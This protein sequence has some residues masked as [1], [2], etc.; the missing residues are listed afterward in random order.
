MAAQQEFWARI[1]DSLFVK[2][3]G[4]F[5]VVQ[6]LPDK[7]DLTVCLNRTF[8]GEA[9]TSS[10]IQAKGWVGRGIKLEVHPNPV[11][12]ADLG[13]TSQ[14]QWAFLQFMFSFFLF[15]GIYLSLLD[16]GWGAPE[17]WH[18]TFI[19]QFIEVTQA[20]T[21]YSAMLILAEENRLPQDEYGLEP[22]I[23]DEIRKIVTVLT[24]KT[25]DYGQAFLRHGVIGMLYRVWDK[26]ARYATL[27]AENRAAKFESRK[28][29]AMDML[30]YSVLI[31]SILEDM[32]ANIP[33]KELHDV[34]S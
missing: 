13:P 10:A 20:M 15:E 26:I 3:P 34:A 28:D 27:S 24:S 1:C 11:L 21:F 31:W 23:R 19:H 14:K 7:L 16:N 5:T 32:Q 8:S 22:L 18:P 4:W 9:V 2:S 29:T 33:A 30:G 25:T 12:Q 6:S 17:Q